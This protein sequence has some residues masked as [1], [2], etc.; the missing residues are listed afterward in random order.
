MD[1]NSA[2]IGFEKEIWDAAEYKQELKGVLPKNFARP[3]LDKRRLGD[4]VDIFTNISMH[5]HG[6]SGAQ[7]ASVDIL[8]R[9]YEY[10]LGK[11]AEQEGKLD[12]EFYTPAC[13]VKNLVEVIKP[14]NGRVYDPCCGSGGMF[15][16]SSRFVEHH[17]GN[18][19]TP[20]VFG[21]DSNPT[22][23]KLYRMNLAIRGI[24][25][26]LG[27]AAADTFSTTCTKPKKWTLYLPIRPST[28]SAGARTNC[29]TMSARNTTSLH[30]GTRASRGFST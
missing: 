12:G 1:S 18:I 27:E 23:W 2:E 24:E 15:V 26:N 6:D 5:K 4:V 3:E 11:F 17:A 10:F 25:A 20:S 9:V 21:Q 30:H 7:G 28:F 14:F 13:V 8:G 29:K 22:T 19:D 16:Q